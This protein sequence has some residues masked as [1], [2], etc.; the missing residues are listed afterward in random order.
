VLAMG[1]G[2]G[3]ANFTYLITVSL[4][5]ALNL[6]IWLMVAPLIAP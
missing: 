5:S 2:S 4:V 3:T 6:D 1:W